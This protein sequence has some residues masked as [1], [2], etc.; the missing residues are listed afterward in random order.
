MCIEL[1][2][3]K[4]LQTLEIFAHNIAQLRLKYIEAFDNFES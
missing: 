4:A 2:T 1:I 3:S